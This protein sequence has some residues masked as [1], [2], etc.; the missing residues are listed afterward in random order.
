MINFATRYSATLTIELFTLVF[1]ELDVV[2]LDTFPH[3]AG[4]KL[5]RNH[6]D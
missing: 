3:R 6:S 5:I 1:S 4:G 2:L